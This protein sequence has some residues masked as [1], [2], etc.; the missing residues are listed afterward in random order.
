MIDLESL[1]EDELYSLGKKLG[2]LSQSR[3]DVVHRIILGFRD[4]LRSWGIFENLGDI[5]WMLWRQGNHGIS[6]SLRI[7][8]AGLNDAPSGSGQNK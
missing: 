5:L 4:G 8:F 6:K 2:E 7:P 3:P 1:T